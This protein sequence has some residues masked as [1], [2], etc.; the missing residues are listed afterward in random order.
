M[1]FAYCPDCA[2]RIYLGPKPWL[3]QPVTCNRCEADLEVTN[4]NPPELDWI[5]ALVSESWEDS[6]SDD[7]LADAS[8]SYP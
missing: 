8:D 2:S 5:D 3:G 4:L 6:E 1:A 7:V